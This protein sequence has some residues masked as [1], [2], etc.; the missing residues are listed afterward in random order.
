MLRS[1][2]EAVA[3]T[4]TLQN[5]AESTEARCAACDAVLALTKSDAACAVL[6]SA[7][8]IHAVINALKSATDCEP[9]LKSTVLTLRN[10][11]RFDS[12][13]TMIVVRLQEGIGAM[14]E[15]L[16]EHIHCSECA[17]H[18]RPVPGLSRSRSSCSPARRLQLPS[19]SC[20]RALPH[21]TR[22]PR[23]ALP[24][25]C[26]RPL[27]APLDVPAPVYPASRPC[28][29]STELL[30]ALLTMLADVSHNAANVQVR[31][32]YVASSVRG[33]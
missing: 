21:A 9:L 27:A 7:G 10:L 20:S 2:E 29:H 31:R 1:K 11:Y 17:S 32:Q 22:A 26:T 24:A 5:T 28:A 30:H 23:Q 15:G 12:K 14:L 25:N 33:R 6:C 13:L 3:L 8:G 19:P 16:R 4:T 18:R